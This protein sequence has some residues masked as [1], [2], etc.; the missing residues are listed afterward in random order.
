M[1]QLSSSMSELVLI[2][3]DFDLEHIG[4]T[5]KIGPNT[6]QDALLLRLTGPFSESRFSKGPFM[7]PYT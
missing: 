1:A 5:L 3:P 6:L 2:Q 4:K 7:G